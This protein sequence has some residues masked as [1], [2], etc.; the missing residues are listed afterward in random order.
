MGQ[1]EGVPGMQDR[2]GIE[3][4]PPDLVAPLVQI[5]FERQQEIPR[6]GIPGPNRRFDLRTDNLCGQKP[7]GVKIVTDQY[8]GLVR[9]VYEHADSSRIGRPSGLDK[10][11]VGVPLDR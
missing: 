3:L 8:A 11:N 4:A 10:L 5:A 1:D 9:E 2:T 7:V 6:Q